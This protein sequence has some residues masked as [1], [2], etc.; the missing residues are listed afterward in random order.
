LATLQ[1]LQEEILILLKVLRGVV[2]GT[3]HTHDSSIGLKDGGV[4]L[5]GG[6]DDEAAQ[7]TGVALAVLEV[8]RLQ[9]ALQVL[10]GGVHFAADAELLKC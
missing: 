1:G 10:N 6:G 9:D 4:V 7:P 2:Q 8:F 3:A 5:G